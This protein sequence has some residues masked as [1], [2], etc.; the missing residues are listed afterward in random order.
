M[1]LILTGAISFGG[2]YM[3]KFIYDK[4]QNSYKEQVIESINETPSILPKAVSDNLVKNG[5]DIN[6]LRQAVL[7][8]ETSHDEGSIRKLA[9]HAPHL[10]YTYL[11]VIKHEVAQKANLSIDLSKIKVYRSDSNS[12]E[13]SVYAVNSDT[14][15]RIYNSTDPKLIDSLT[16]VV[17]LTNR[18]KQQRRDEIETGKPVELDRADALAGSLAN[19]YLDMISFQKSLNKKS[20]GVER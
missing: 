18:S 11:T 4:A 17:K 14:N 15:E 20:K 13:M 9:E 5:I 6:S 3:G 12:G 8:Y 2:V 16:N 1:A 7:D 19:A 10:I